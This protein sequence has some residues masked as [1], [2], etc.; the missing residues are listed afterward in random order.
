[1][2][3]YGKLLADGAKAL[4]QE[5]FGRGTDDDPVAFLYSQAEERIANSPPDLVDFHGLIIP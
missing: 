3:K 5:L 4:G 2:Q 1:V